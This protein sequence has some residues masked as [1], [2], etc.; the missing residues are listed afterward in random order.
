M[1]EQ[2]FV[3]LD[4]ETT[5]I[6]APANRMVEIAAVKF[7]LGSPEDRRFESL[8][9]PE[10]SIPNE[11]I[12]I[13]GITDD[14]VADAPSGREVM[15]RFLDFIGKDSLLIA[16]N[17]P[18]D[19]GFLGCELERAEL[20]Y[21]DNPVLDTID[22]Y[23]RFFPGQPSYSL[24]SLVKKYGLGETQAHRALADAIYVRMLMDHAV[25]KLSTISSREEL[26]SRLTSYQLADWNREPGQ[27]PERLADL[28]QAVDDRQRIVIHYRG[29]SQTPTRRVIRPLGTY[30]IGAKIYIRAHCER[31]R[32]ERTFRIDRIEQFEIV[33]E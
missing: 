23:Q 33:D 11:V 20:S 1:A 21:P 15:S 17:A 10:R 6:W 9:N 16:H 14:M 18:F 24:L 13:H 2:E 28:K 5:G 31:A 32:A 7:R 4:T 26:L 25:N 12:R 22:V 29:N 30:T 27:F 19:I 3:A 8:V